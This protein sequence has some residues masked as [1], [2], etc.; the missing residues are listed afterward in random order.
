MKR[1]IAFFMYLCCMAA[2]HAQDYTP[3]REV[4]ETDSGI[5]VTYHFHGGIQQDDPLHEGAKFWKIPGF[6]LNS[7]IGQPA[8]PSRWDTFVIPEGVSPVVEVI[9]SA[10]TDTSFLMAPAYPFLSMSDTIGYTQDR[11]PDIHPYEGLFPTSIALK[12]RIRNYRGQNLL[13]VGIAPI[14]YDYIHA[15][16]RVYSMI[17]YRIKYENHTN[18]SI[19]VKKKKND[20]YD[21]FLANTTLNYAIKSGKE[22]SLRSEN[23]D[24]GLENTVGYLI[25]TSPSL[26]EP[27]HRFAQWKLTKG[28]NTIVHP[29]SLSNMTEESK[30]NTILSLINAY[31]EDGYNIKYLLMV[32]DADSLPGKR[33]NKYLDDDGFIHYSN[34]GTYYTDYYYECLGDMQN[35]APSLFCGRIPAS[36]PTEINTIFD[37]II[38]YEKNPT[39]N[40]LFYQTVVNCA[41][42]DGGIPRTQESRVD[43]KRGI[44]TSETIIHYL[45]DSIDIPKNVKHIY[46]NRLNL[47]PQSTWCYSPVLSPG[48]PLPTYLHNPSEWTGNHENVTDSINAGCFLF[49]YMGHGEIDKWANWTEDSDEET[50]LFSQEYAEYLHN[51]GMYPVVMSMSCHSGEYQHSSNCPTE[52]FLKKENAGA[53][54]VIAPTDKTLGGLSE[55][56]LEGM[57][58]SMWPF[59]GT[60]VNHPIDSAVYDLGSMLSV[61]KEWMGYMQVYND[62][63]HLVDYTY[64]ED[65]DYYQYT[66]EVFNLFGDPSMQIYTAKP[67]SFENVHISVSNGM[68]RVQTGV[69]DT[70][71]SFSYP[72]AELAYTFVGSDVSFPYETSVDSMVVCV[73]KHNYIPYIQSFNKD[74]VL[75]NETISDI[76]TYLSNRINV[77]R[78]VTDA[79]PQGDVIIQQGAD[80]TMQGGSVTLQPGTFIQKGARVRINPR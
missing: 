22:K 19:A 77:G 35:N 54:G 30:V 15:T 59:P 47:E 46:L 45:E 72:H 64:N 51:D 36:T 12:G 73:D 26:E 61:S 76:R 14:Q 23:T 40:A 38:D 56:L 25:L 63:T 75:Q 18:E 41:V 69:P 21:P 11:V 37:K 42:F 57:I 53:V 7:R 10:Y 68:I 70:K 58:N 32:G 27:V 3:T 20:V 52:I 39:D 2:M 4:V 1:Y 48:G 34:N 79:K 6:S 49:S 71:V 66:V 28:F 9:D 13:N 74:V 60:N 5:V 8:F 62:S 65:P 80:V 24:P 50:T 78:H 55:C 33:M 29:L 67:Q 17:K 44:Y 31:N 43:K 16:A